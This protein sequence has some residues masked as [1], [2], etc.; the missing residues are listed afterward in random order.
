[1]TPVGN[2]GIGTT[3]PNA[4]TNQTS[5]TINGTNNGR[6]DLKVGNAQKGAVIASANEMILD[7]GASPMQFYTGSTL[8]MLINTSGNVGIGTTSPDNKLQVVAGNGNVQAWF[9]ESSYTSAMLRVGGIIV[10]GGDYSL[11]ITEMTVT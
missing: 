10:P 1:M 7:A 9:G 8:H 6:L 2:I 5:L 3:S 11:N 4:F